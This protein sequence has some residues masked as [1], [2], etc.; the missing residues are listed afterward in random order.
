[1]AS[2]GQASQAS[3]DHRELINV[4]VVWRLAGALSLHSRLSS[5]S[6]YFHSVND[7]IRWCT[8]ALSYNVYVVTAIPLGSHYIYRWY[9]IFEW[10]IPTQGQ[11]EHDWEDSN[12][13]NTVTYCYRQHTNIVVGSHWLTQQHSGSNT[14]SHSF[15]EH[16]FL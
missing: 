5:I 15:T 1:M 3:L 10:N 12:D 8:D 14:W 7:Q 9:L 11:S 13:S 4:T 6:H 16:S 2:H